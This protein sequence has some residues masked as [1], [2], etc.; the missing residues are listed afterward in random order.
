MRPSAAEGVNAAGAYA[1]AQEFW[2]VSCGMAWYPGRAARSKTV[3][4]REW[5]PYLPVAN[6]S[7]FMVD[8]TKTE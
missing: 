7:N 3:A 5:M 8:A 2:N 6:N 4:G 1:A